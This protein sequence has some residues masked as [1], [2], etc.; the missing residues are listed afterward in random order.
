ME[1]SVG[2]ERVVTWSDAG[3]REAALVQRCAA[4][5]EAA[6][7]ELVAE[8]R[9]AILQLGLNLLGDEDEA[10]DLSQEV[11][12]TVFRKIS[13]F[14]RKSALRTWIYRIAINQ[15]RNRHRLWKRRHRNDQVSID[16]HIAEHGE[17]YSGEESTPD[18]VLAKKELAASLKRAFDSLPFDQRTAIVLREIDGMTI[19]D[20]ATSMNMITGCVKSRLT[21]ARRA[22]RAKLREARSL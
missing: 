11:F 5:D 17:F 6:F 10:L 9:Y 21:K 15:A 2:Q 13:S 18:Q 8:H 16:D 1:L 22:L 4:G 14:E 20:I 12:L 3:G 7:A 19:E